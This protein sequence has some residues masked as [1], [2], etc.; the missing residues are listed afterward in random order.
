MAFVSR[1][2]RST[3]DYGSLTTLPVRSLSHTP[4]NPS[5]NTVGHGGDTP[6]FTPPRKNH[7]VLVLAVAADLHIF[8]AT[9]E[10]VC[11]GSEQSKPAQGASQPSLCSRQHDRTQSRTSSRTVSGVHAPPFCRLTSKTLVCVRFLIGSHLYSVVYLQ[12]V[13]PGSY[14]E[15]T[16]PGLDHA[17]APFSSTTERQLGGGPPGMSAYTPG[18]GAYKKG[19]T[20][21]DAQ[22]KEVS[23][24]AFVSGVARLSKDTSSATTA[25]GPGQ[26]VY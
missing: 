7:Q 16:D 24:C 4:A 22:R 15:L 19:K 6:G 11:R 20:D 2:Q 5:N 17:Y 26:G 10:S 8:G 1:A 3:G 13:G 12:V 18:P 9:T 25:P 23:G 21:W 14:G